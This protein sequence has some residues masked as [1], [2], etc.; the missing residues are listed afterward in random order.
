M[1]RRKNLQYKELE[2][3]GIDYKNVNLKDTSQFEGDERTTFLV[4]G[5]DTVLF[6]RRKV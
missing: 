5:L 3:L 6:E 2:E 4:K 1:E